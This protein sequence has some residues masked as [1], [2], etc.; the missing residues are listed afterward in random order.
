M[1]WCRLYDQLC[2]G[3]CS[4]FVGISEEKSKKYYK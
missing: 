1:L 4:D 2:D 3:E